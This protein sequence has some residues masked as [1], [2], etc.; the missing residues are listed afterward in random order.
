MRRRY[1]IE[2]DKFRIFEDGEVVHMSIL[3]PHGD[4][5]IRNLVADWVELGEV[6]KRYEELGEAKDD[7]IKVLESDYIDR[8]T[9]LWCSVFILKDSAAADAAVEQFDARFS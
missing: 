4:E 3:N 9:E 8:R 6:I 5:W 1:N 2:E 7:R